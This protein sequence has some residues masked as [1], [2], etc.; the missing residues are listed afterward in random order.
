MVTVCCIKQ[1]SKYG[2]EY[3]N[4]LHAMV[5]RNTFIFDWDF[6]CFTDDAAGIDPKIRIEPLPH[7]AVGWWVKMGLYQKEVPGI[8]SEKLLFLDLD[9]VI[10]GFLDP[11]LIFESDHALI[12]DYPAA[13]LPPGNHHQKDGNTSAILLTVGSR[14][15]IWEAFLRE[16]NPAGRYWSEQDWLNKKHPGSFDLLPESMAQSYK[17]HKLQDRRPECSIVMFH[18]KPKPA[19]CGGWVAEEWRTSRRK[20]HRK[21]NRGQISNLSPEEDK[22]RG[23]I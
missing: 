14:V 5:V 13:Y 10:P 4:I 19:D 22:N 11:V 2:P 8:A 16:K 7:P 3:V 18:G 12:K 15:H 20:R 1:G 23:Q 21:S 9:V 6:V 17:L